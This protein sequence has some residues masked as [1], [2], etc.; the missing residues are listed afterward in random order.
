LRAASSTAAAIGEKTRRNQIVDGLQS[1]QLRQRF[2]EDFVHIFTSPNVSNSDILINIL[3][4]SFKAIFFNLLIL[5]ATN[6]GEIV[7]RTF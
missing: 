3:S 5:V 1:V 7:T 6:L 4:C 2:K